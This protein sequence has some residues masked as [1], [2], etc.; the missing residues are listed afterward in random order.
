MLY[1]SQKKRNSPIMHKKSFLIDPD[2]AGPGHLAI[3]LNDADIVPVILVAFTLIDECKFCIPLI[4]K[5]K[6]MQHSRFPGK[7]SGK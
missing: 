2:G 3:G 5:Y 4:M 7:R 6:P 1:S